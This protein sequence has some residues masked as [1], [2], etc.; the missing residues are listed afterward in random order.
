MLYPHSKNFLEDFGH[1]MSKIF[2]FK[3]S[4]FCGFKIDVLR[5]RGG[6]VTPVQKPCLLKVNMFRNMPAKFQGQGMSTCLTMM[7]CPIGGYRP[8]QAC[9]TVHLVSMA[10]ICFKSPTAEDISGLKR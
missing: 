6:T 4:I 5:Y 10:R 7:V 3:N 2:K 9:L 1:L 8:N